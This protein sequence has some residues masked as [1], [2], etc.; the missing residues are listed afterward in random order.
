MSRLP[1]L[2][3]DEPDPGQALAHPTLGPVIVE[4]V[5]RRTR[6]ESGVTILI[7]GAS[8]A[9]GHALTPADDDEDEDVA[10]WHD[11]DYVQALVDQAAHERAFDGTA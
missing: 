11:P 1:P 8:Y 10:P 6:S 3:G 9:D 4:R 2:S 5:L 7:I